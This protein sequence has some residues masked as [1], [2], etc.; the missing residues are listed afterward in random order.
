MSQSDALVVSSCNLSCCPGG[1]RENDCASSRQLDCPFASKS[2]SELTAMSKKTAG[3]SQMKARARPGPFQF[4]T[5]MLLAQAWVNLHPYPSR[6]EREH[7]PHIPA[8]GTVTETRSKTV[9]GANTSLHLHVSCAVIGLS[10]MSG[11]C[12]EWAASLMLQ[13]QGQ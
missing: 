9:I 1:L 7:F 6:P 2:H 13:H 3:Q 5:H 4:I 11:F 10:N 8:E 12:S